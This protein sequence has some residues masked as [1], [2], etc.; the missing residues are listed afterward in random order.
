M[1]NILMLRNI[2][3][4]N[5]RLKLILQLELKFVYKPLPDI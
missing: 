1:T 4:N 5:I 3:Y 2:D